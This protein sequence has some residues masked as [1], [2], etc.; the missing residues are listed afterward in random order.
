[1]EN[2]K[3]KIILPI[4]A[5]WLC[6]CAMMRHPDDAWFARDKAWHFGISAGL[7]AGLAAAAENNGCSDGEAMAFAVAFTMPIGAGKEAY[8]RNVKKTYASGK[9]L[10][11]DLAGA[12][13][14]GAAGV[15]LQR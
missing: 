4:L 9:D 13:A 10:V 3:N 5:L 6:G 1:M 2:A 11:W 12:L 15:W 8:D 7:S 14:G